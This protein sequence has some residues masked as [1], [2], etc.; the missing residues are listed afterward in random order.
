VTSWSL[1][2]G[3]AHSLPRAAPPP[4]P[5]GQS[6]TQAKAVAAEVCIAPPLGLIMD[7]L[8]TVRKP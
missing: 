3:E 8:T 4:R 7:L 1:L 5:Y 2:I 6:E